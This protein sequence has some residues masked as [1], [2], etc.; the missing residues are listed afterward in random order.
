MSVACLLADLEPHTLGDENEQGWTE[1]VS[2]ASARGIRFLCWSVHVHQKHS[3]TQ[4]RKVISG[5]FEPPYT[6]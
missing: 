6:A 5:G 1:D 3:N 2:W 4:H